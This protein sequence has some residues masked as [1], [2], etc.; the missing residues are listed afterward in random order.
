M[1]GGPLQSNLSSPIPAIGIQHND[2]NEGWWFLFHLKCHF[3]L[4]SNSN[5]GLV[6]HISHHFR[7]MASFPLKNRHFSYPAPFN[8]QF[9]NDPLA[10]DGW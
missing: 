7:D 8:P 10:L 6:G 4:V 3:L 2:D 5:F 9:E 1:Y